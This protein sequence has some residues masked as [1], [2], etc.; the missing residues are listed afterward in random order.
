VALNRDSWKGPRP[1]TEPR[2]ELDWCCPKFYRP[3]LAVDRALDEASPRPNLTL[4]FIFASYPA[5]CDWSF[6]LNCD[7]PFAKEGS[8]T[9]LR[10][11]LLKI[12]KVYP[13]VS[14]NHLIEDTDKGRDTDKLNTK[15]EA[16]GNIISDINAPSPRQPCTPTRTVSKHTLKMTPFKEMYGYH[17]CFNIDGRWEG[18]AMLDRVNS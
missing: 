6:A 14:V 12:P 4:E 8:A 7:N 13:L 9:R 1:Q 5:K 3:F 15:L 11:R 16:Y 10:K 17:P 18:P 2:V